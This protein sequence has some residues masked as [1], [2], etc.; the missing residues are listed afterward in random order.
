MAKY[1]KQK[2]IV[3]TSN[4]ETKVIAK[5]LVSVV[6][7]LQHELQE[8]ENQKVNKNR[9]PKKITFAYASLEL[10]RRLDK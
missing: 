10:S 3:G 4:L 1:K 9:K 7:R 8:L 2:K 6:I 5:P